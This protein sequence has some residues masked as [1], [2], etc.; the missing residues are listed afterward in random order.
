MAD[1]LVDLNLPSEPIQR[2][3]TSAFPQK[4]QMI[5]QRSRPP[6][7][8]TPFEVFDRGVFT[9]NDQ[10]FVCW[11]W[12]VI[13]QQVDVRTFKLVIRGD[14]NNP[15]SLSPV[16]ILAMPWLEVV[17][18]NQCSGNSRSLFQPRVAG[19]QWDH[20]GRILTGEKRYHE[21]DHLFA[22]APPI[23][24]GECSER[25]TP[26]RPQCIRSRTQPVSH[27]D[28]D[29]PPGPYPIP[30]LDKNGSHNQPARPDLEP[31][32]IYHF[33]VG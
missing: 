3:L 18:V 7:L 30:W 23:S 9:P 8:E 21:P 13:P 4:R 10:F 26:A 28:P 15:L 5:L 6:L 11:H 19:G 33:K 24:C 20:G 1:G 17:A 12:A 27:V 16:D 22:I 29:G 2:E 32:H 14:V 31:S 25:W